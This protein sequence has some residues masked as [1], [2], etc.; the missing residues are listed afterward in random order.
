MK[1]QEQREKA[2]NQIFWEDEKAGESNSILK[3]ACYFL[4]WQGSNNPHIRGVS[5]E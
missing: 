2:A 4:K 5:G 3:E 1:I